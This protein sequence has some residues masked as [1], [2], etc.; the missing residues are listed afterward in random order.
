[1]PS[2]R[3]RSLCLRSHTHT[4]T[5]SHARVLLCPPGPVALAANET[6]FGTQRPRARAHESARKRNPPQH[7]VG[8]LSAATRL[9]RSIRRFRMHSSFSF[10]LPLRTDVS[11]CRLSPRSTFTHRRIQRRRQQTSDNFWRSL[12]PRRVV[13]CVRLVYSCK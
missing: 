6:S 8:S 12:Y 5:H 7:C 10:H 13:A 9:L 1:M 2:Q 4:H 3:S 11:R